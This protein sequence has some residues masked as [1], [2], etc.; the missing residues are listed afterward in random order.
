MGTVLE[1]GKV[2]SYQGIFL[3][4]F[5]VVVST[6]VLF[7]PEITAINAGRNSW[8]SVL[9]VATAYGLLTALVII[10]LGKIFP[11]KTL[12]EYLPIIL[13]PILG[14]IIGAAY[15]F[16]FIH[17]NSVIVREFGDLLLTSFMPETPL[18]SFIIILLILGAWATKEGLEVICRTNEFIFPFFI[19]SVTFIFILTVH[20]ADFTRLLPVME[21]GMKP[22]IRGAWTPM[23][24]RG[25]VIVATMFFP[26]LK[27]ANNAGKFLT[28]SIFLMGFVLTIATMFTTAMFGELTPYLT[29][30][31][32][33]LARCVSIGRFFERM[34]ALVLV[35]WVAGVTVK[36]ATYY[37]I[38]A[39][40]TAQLLGL[41][42]YR[43]IVFPIG[44]LLGIWSL[45]LFQNSSELIEWVTKVFPIY[46][47][48]F[49]I[50]IPL[51]LL[52]VALLRKKGGKK[53]DV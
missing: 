37:Y 21:H 28:Y 52:I 15:I 35:M 40:G 33:E 18:I 46:A 26:Y 10:K 38:S 50:A 53:N 42:D 5:T 31:F 44:L 23:A 16:W 25:Q 17:F 34:E 22:V 27:D 36:V 39:L 4:L 20:D 19:L 14:K 43:P 48:L 7:V 8:I 47:Y 2:S 45:E 6:A 30:P 32:F 3:L 41:S 12:I 11:D 29:F 51:L 1:K 13:G 49:E 9:V 24:W